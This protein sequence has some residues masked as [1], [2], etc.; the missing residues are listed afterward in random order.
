RSPAIGTSPQAAQASSRAS[1]C[2]ASFCKST[3]YK[4]QAG[5]LIRNIGFQQKIWTP[6][7]P[8]SVVRSRSLQNFEKS[9][10]GSAAPR[11]PAQRLGLPDVEDLLDDLPRGGH[12]IAH[13]DQRPGVPRRQFAGGDIG[14]HLRGQFGQPHH[15]G[16][17]A[18][19]LADDLGDVFLAAFEFAG[20]RMIA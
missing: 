11:E 8:L 12:R 9:E 5:P 18:A 16:D 14:L 3:Q 20:E 7:T 15:V 13:A 19:A 6:S 4:Q 17:M 1:K 2:N 10:W